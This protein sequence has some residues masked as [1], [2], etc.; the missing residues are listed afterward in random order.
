MAKRRTFS[1]GFKARA[2]KEDLRRD[3]TMQQIA[4][5][6]ALHPNQESSGIG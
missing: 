2:A 1:P 6:H 4:A 5:R 3:Q